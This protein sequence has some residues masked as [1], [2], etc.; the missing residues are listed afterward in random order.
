M[1]VRDRV[2]LGICGPRTWIL[3][4]IQWLVFSDWAGYDT[5]GWEL[6]HDCYLHMTRPGSFHVGIYGG[7]STGGESNISLKVRYW[8]LGSREVYHVA[9]VARPPQVTGSLECVQELVRPLPHED[10]CVSSPIFNYIPN[11]LS[12][13]QTQFQ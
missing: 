2:R 3:V 1:G 4:W 13:I 9:R 7:K 11:L 5:S 12:P 8:F 6:L 10:V